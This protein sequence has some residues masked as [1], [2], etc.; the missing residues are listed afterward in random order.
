[1]SNKQELIAKCPICQTKNSFTMWNSVNVT[2]DPE[3][4]SDILDLSIFKCTCSN[5]GFT[6][7]IDYNCMYHDME[8]KIVV[9]FVNKNDPYVS[10]YEKLLENFRKDGYLVRIVNSIFDLKEKLIIFDANLDD[11]IVE[12]Y[13]MIIFRQFC[14]DY[15]DE[16][17]DEEK[18]NNNVYIHFELI[19]SNNTSYVINI[20][21]YDYRLMMSIDF[22]DDAYK[23]AC[24]ACLDKLPSIKNDNYVIDYNKAL[25][26]IN[27]NDL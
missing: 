18:I 24:D 11:R 22:F 17:F 14:E 12:I 16:E 21:S 19:N 6:E 23:T 3:L 2:L 10:K 7:I 25:K 26:I 1:M 13:K 15:L 8:N 9:F 27:E 4:K 5:C 20:Y